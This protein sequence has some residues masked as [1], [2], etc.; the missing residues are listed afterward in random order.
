MS[1]TVQ[2][3]YAKVRYSDLSD[4]S[5][6]LMSRTAE[7]FR[8]LCTGEHRYVF[9]RAEWNGRLSRKL[10]PWEEQEGKDLAD[11]SVNAV[12]QGYKTATFHRYV[13]S[14]HTLIHLYS[15][16]CRHNL[17]P[18]SPYSSPRLDRDRRVL[19]SISPDETKT[20]R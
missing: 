7:N 19:Q 17:C 13:P 20:H 15:C 12:P 11:D 18:S 10:G 3:H 1:R 2:R 16:S 8:Q 4:Q 9:F 14:F 6:G 5:S